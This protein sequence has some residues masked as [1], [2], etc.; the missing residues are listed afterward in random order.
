MNPGFKNAFHI[1]GTFASDQMLYVIF[2][3]SPE[4]I[5]QEIGRKKQ[6]S[7]TKCQKT[8]DNLVVLY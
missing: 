4:M 2:L 1:E 3:E 6:S 7:A 5:L 8:S